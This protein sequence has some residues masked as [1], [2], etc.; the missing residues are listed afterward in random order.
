MSEQR[1]HTTTA[2][3]IHWC[4]IPLYAYGILKQLNDLDDLQQEGLMLFEVLFALTFLFIV[5]ARY[6][7]MKRFKTFSGARQPVH[8]VHRFI[9]RSVHLGMYSSLILLPTSGLLIAALYA[10]GHQSTDGLWMAAAL[11]VHGFAA[12]L[13][14]L[15][16][17]IHVSAAV[18]S[19]LK[20][21]GI[22]SS[23]VPFLSEERPFEQH[24]W[25]QNM[26]SVE[27]QL[28]DKIEGLFSNKKS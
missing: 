28:Y 13:S 23:M 2:R 9:A 24:G 26:A 22:W 3:L 15:L 17:A 1:R 7:Y 14:Y 8:V 27:H 18:Y 11:E 21:E 4:F 25:V 16:I 10:Q 20:G 6:T 19:R 5:V 12:S